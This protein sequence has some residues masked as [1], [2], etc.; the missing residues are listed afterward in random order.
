MEQVA[1]SV[2]EL[3][4]QHRGSSWQVAF[5][6]DLAAA[7]MDPQR[8]DQLAPLCARKLQHLLSGM[9]GPQ[10]LRGLVD[11]AGVQLCAAVDPRTRR[12]ALGS[13]R[14]GTERAALMLLSDAQ[15]SDVDRL[16]AMQELVKMWD[17]ARPAAALPAVHLA[18]GTG[19][20]S[21]DAAALALGTHPQCADV[22]E[23]TARLARQVNIH[24]AEYTPGLRE[25]MNQ[26]GLELASNCEPLR[27]HGLRFVAALPSL[28]HDTQGA[29]V[30]RLLRET[31]RRLREDVQFAEVQGDHGGALPW[32]LAICV[33]VLAWLVSWAP[34]RWTA[35]ITRTLVRDVARTFIAGEDMQTA[36]PALDALRATGR[37]ATLDQLGELVVSEPEADVYSQRVL[38][39][40]G[41]AGSGQ[42]ERNGAGIARGHVSVKVSALCSD[43]DPDDVDG[44]WRRVGPRLTAIMVLA[45]QRGVFINLDAE[46]YAV[47]NLTLEMLKRALDGTPELRGWDGA[48]IVVQAYLRDAADHL[49]D[50][51]E[52]AQQ[53]GIRMPVRL[54]K[55]AYWDA[56]T[57]EADAHDHPAPQFLF[58][59]ETDVMFQALCAEVLAHP[60]A[61]QL[62]IG[63]HNLRDHCFGEAVRSLVYPGAPAIEHQALHM[64]YEG[65]STAMARAGWC[66]RNYVPVGSL[67]VGMA[68]LVRRILENSSQVGVLTAARHGVDLPRLLVPPLQQVAQ[69]SQAGLLPTDPQLA[70]GPAGHMPLFYNTAPMRL[71]HPEHRAALET[72]LAAPLWQPR[73]DPTRHGPHLEVYSPSDQRLLVGSLQM[74]SADDVRAAVD[75]AVDFAPQWAAWPPGRRAV[76]LL[77]AAEILRCERPSWAALVI[78]E[79]GKSRLEALGDV[80]EAIDFLQFYA[81]E[82]HRLADLAPAARPRGVLAV[83]APWNFPLAIP[84]G[85]ASAALVAGNTVLLKSAEQTPLV[86]ERFVLLLHR[87]GVPSAALQHLVGDGPGVGAPLV[88]DPRVD[89][90]VFTGSAGVGSMLHRTMATRPRGGHTALAITEMGGKNA[91]VVTGNADLDEAISGALRSAFGHAGQ[92]CS[93]ASRILVDRGICDAFCKRFAHAAADWTVGVAHLPGTRINPVVTAQDRDRLLRDAELVVAEALAQ[94]GQVL[95]DRSRSAGGEPDLADATVIGPVVVTLPAQAALRPE[96][97]AQRELFGPIVHII[98]YEGLEQAVQVWRAPAYALTGGIYAQSQDDV[99]FLTDA[100]RVGN[101]YV[102]RSITGARVA[103]EPFGGFRMS[104]TGP[105]AG[106]RDYLG[107]ML[108]LPTVTDTPL[109]AQA[110]VIIGELVHAQDH[111]PGHPGHDGHA[112]HSSAHPDAATVSPGALLASWQRSPAGEARTQRLVAQFLAWHHRHRHSLAAGAD[113]NRAIAGQISHNRWA[114]SKGHAVVLAGSGRPGAHA[115]VHGV[116]ALA[117]GGTVTVLGCSREAES[118]WRTLAGHL[119]DPAQ[120]QVTG[121]PDAQSLAHFLRQPH[122]VT[123]ILDGQAADWGAALPLAVHGGAGGVAGTADGLRTILGPGCWPPLDH[124]ELLARAHLHVTSVAINTMRHGA[125]LQVQHSGVAATGALDDGAS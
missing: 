70:C 115:V 90:V 17:S 12:I 66:V 49:R 16:R 53:R 68:Y 57:V 109:D 58:K 41:A 103:V 120:L 55:G 9:A 60:S 20:L 2:L 72:A 75:R 10:S 30:T 111:H 36:R 85:M 26:W 65:L 46:H 92:K 24:I 40:V 32:W 15:G 87:C 67:L 63:S 114:L 38:G 4:L 37:D 83:I 62:C 29:E 107:A 33:A 35:A 102:N 97:H 22:L 45:R 106:G 80:D 104:G 113:T 27:L 101:L 54:V 98:P 117:T 84:V 5:C 91:I 50:V 48:G 23:A 123:V 77:R 105:K 21:A 96:S 76:C 13:E 94:G 122:I 42:A 6:A 82:A 78:R 64:T 18:L 125:P 81:R 100:A 121:V 74:H 71:Y 118:A 25:Q 11:V 116:A 1:P 39:L 52:Y 14:F 79:S 8:A 69:A 44:T 19:R 47:R 89:G 86:V 110:R 95:V 34:A 31:L 7:V 108:R 56:E 93:A 88:G 59:P 28:D 51:L 119:G 43:Y 99:D 112:D 3:E 124:P 73:A 61:L